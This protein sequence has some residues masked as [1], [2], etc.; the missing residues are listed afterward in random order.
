MLGG[1][2]IYSIYGQKMFKFPDS[3]AIFSC[4][5]YHIQ[6]TIMIIS[7]IIPLDGLQL[8]GNLHQFLYDSFGSS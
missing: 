7:F 6:L 3:Y 1:C 2:C 5:L 4:T 8:D